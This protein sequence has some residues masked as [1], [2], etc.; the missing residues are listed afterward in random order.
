MIDPPHS[1]VASL[2]SQ[3]RQFGPA[4]NSLA[5]ADFLVFIDIHMLSTAFTNFETDSET[6]ISDPVPSIREWR[7][8]WA[9]WDAVTRGMTPDKDLCSKPIELRND[10]I[11]YL[12][13]IPTFCGMLL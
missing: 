6:S 5:K 12:G 11:F 7:E 3:I 8:L 4:E 13:H 10:L 2:S 1:S 9:A